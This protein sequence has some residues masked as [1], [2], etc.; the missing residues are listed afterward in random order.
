MSVSKSDTTSKLLYQIEKDVLWQLRGQ[1]Q[2]LHLEMHDGGLILRGR[3]YSFY[4]K[5]LA[6]HAVKTRTEIPVV[7]N[8]VEVH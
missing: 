1:I 3:A 6:L 8:R 7:A 5:Q 2:R 4:G